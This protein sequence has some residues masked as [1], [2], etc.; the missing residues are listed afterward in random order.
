MKR[1]KTDYG[2]NYQD[3]LKSDLRGIETFIGGYFHDCSVRLKSD[4]R[5]IETKMLCEEIKDACMLKS[6]LRGIETSL[7]DSQ[8]NKY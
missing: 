5:G 2:E 7:P 8:F 6:D 4:L 3:R 1:D